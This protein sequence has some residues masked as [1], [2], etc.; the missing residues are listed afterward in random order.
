MFVA[1]TTPNASL[2]IDWQKFASG[3]QSEMAGSIMFSNSKNV[4]Y[5]YGLVFTRVISVL[6]IINK[7]C[8]NLK[9]L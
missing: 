8:Y 2:S 7:Y 9:V 4:F 3:N 5:S 1:H 6:H